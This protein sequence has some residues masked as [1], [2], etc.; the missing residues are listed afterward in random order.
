[1]KNFKVS[2]NT[3]NIIERISIYVNSAIR[4]YEKQQGE[5][6]MEI[7]YKKCV[8]YDNNITNSGN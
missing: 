3:N 1:M 5:L 4:D 2:I 6:S 8:C 7:E